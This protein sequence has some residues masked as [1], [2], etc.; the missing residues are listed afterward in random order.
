MIMFNKHNLH[1]KV[2]GDKTYP[3]R[4][5]NTICVII[6][7]TTIHVK[8]HIMNRSSHKFL[9]HD[10]ETAITEHAAALIVAEAY[11]AVAERGRFLMV[12]AGGNSPRILY[13]RLAQGVSGEVLE[14]YKLP[15]PDG[16]SKRRETLHQLPEKSWFFM[17]DERCVPV[18]HPDSNER[19]IRE[20]LL[21]HSGIGEHHLVRMAGEKADTEEAAR[22][23]EGSIRSFFPIEES[24]TSEK[25]PRFDLILLGLGDDGH[26]ASLFE[27]N[28][29]AL[30]EQSRWVIALNAPFGKP[31][32]KRLSLTLP[33]INHARNILFFTT[34]KAKRE[35]AEKVFLEQEKSVPA[36]LVKP[37]NGTLF[38]FTAQP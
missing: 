30:Q 5:H 9:Y 11:R 36:S 10:N 13:K 14:H 19:M 7:S 16:W 26:T 2:G 35:L 25:F 23:Y 37:V 15:F 38:W 31:P 6:R 32:G 21:P 1:N 17:D 8:Q 34:G 24:G 33:L 27:D 4:L 3:L 22:E 28:A 12:L 29:E 18:D 20:T